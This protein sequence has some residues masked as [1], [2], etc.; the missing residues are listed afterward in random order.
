MGEVVIE[1]RVY[2]DERLDDPPDLREPQV[3]A[4]RRRQRVA[5]VEWRAGVRWLQPVRPESFELQATHLVDLG[6]LAELAMGAVELLVRSGEVEKVALQA[7]NNQTV[8]MHVRVEVA[9]PLVEPQ[10]L[11]LVAAALGH[12]PEQR[13]RFG[14]WD[15][16]TATLEVLLR[17]TLGVVR[18]E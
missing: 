2:P 13:V 16:P 15:E 1:R 6:A 4:D 8:A 18:P 5:L 11:G 9:G 10:R 12:L 14:E 17:Q 7:R 3:L